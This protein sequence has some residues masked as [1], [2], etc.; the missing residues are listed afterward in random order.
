MYLTDEMSPENPKR[1]LDGLISISDLHPRL[2][3]RP[4][5]AR[6]WAQGVVPWPAPLR[7]HFSA[8][9]YPTVTRRSTSSSRTPRMT[10]FR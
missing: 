2:R 1:R 3:T 8:C 5:T 9:R 6:D 7:L 10:D 4:R